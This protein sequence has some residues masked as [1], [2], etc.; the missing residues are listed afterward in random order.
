MSATDA[1]TITSALDALTRYYCA[2]ERE[3][4]AVLYIN[5]AYLEVLNSLENLEA[6]NAK[7]R[8][9]LADAPKCETCEAMLDCD[10]CLRADGSQ[11]ERR[12]LSAENAKLRELVLVLKNCADENGDCDACPINDAKPVRHPW[13]GCDALRDM[14]CELGIE[15]DA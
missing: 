4:S 3:E 1:L 11:K 8:E 9:E 6:E 12:R 14:M 15:E 2:K 10:E 7:L 13:F 5:D